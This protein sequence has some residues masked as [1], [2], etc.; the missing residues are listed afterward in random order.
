MEEEVEVEERVAEERAVAVLEP[1]VV[2]AEEL[3][4]V[5]VAL[6]VAKAEEPAV[7]TPRRRGRRSSMRSCAVREQRTRQE[8]RI[9]RTS[10]SCAPSATPTAGPAAWSSRP[11]ASTVSARARLAPSAKARMGIGQSRHDSLSPAAKV[12]N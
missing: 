2:E 8:R 1:V 5:A 4:V 9:V 10:K 3:E 12:R 6:E 11:F 7:T